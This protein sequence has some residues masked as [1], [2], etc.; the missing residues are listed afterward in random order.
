MNVAGYGQGVKYAG[1]DA[2]QRL[3]KLEDARI[4]AYGTMRQQDDLAKNQAIG[5]LVGTGVGLARGLYQKYLQDEKDADVQRGVQARREYKDATKG[6][7]GLQKE[8]ADIVALEPRISQ[9]GRIAGVS[10]NGRE[11]ATGSLTMGGKDT[12]LVSNNPWRDFLA[13]S[14]FFDGLLDR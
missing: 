4:E 14:K 5:S 13:G 6:L 10:T 8:M 2:L 9:T 1:I 3:A 11:G 12:Q 7:T